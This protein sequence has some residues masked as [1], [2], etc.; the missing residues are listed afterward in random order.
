MNSAAAQRTFPRYD[1]VH[2]VGVVTRLDEQG[3][4]VDCDGRDWSCT[5]A[6]SCLLA[7]GVGDTVL[8]SGPDSSR[9]F[10]IAVITQ[11]D[12]SSARIELR[13]DVTIAS[14]DGD[15]TLQGS[16]NTRLAGGAQ[17]RI[18]APA[19]GLQADDA[20]CRVGH[21][22]YAG[23]DVK[24][25]V[26]IL[27]LVGKVCETAVDRLVQLSRNLVRIT[28]ESEHVRARVLDSQ[29][30]QSARLH[31]PYTVVTG[32]ELVKVDAKQIHVG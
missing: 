18:E 16:G 26:G 6:A 2:L 8:I 32:E 28:E 30:S 25:S 9:V 14:L 11:A 5:R 3:Y 12:A 13:G 27:R 21:M 1:P 15:L 23:A 24:A 17:V 20:D 4:V 10:L 19:F 29:A 22:R 7:P 31:S